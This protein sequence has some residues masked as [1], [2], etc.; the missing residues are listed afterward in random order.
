MQVKKGVYDDA[1]VLV[2]EF[3]VDYQYDEMGRMLRRDDGTDVTDYFY[4]GWDIWK[5]VTGE[6]V[7]EYLVPGLGIQ[8]FLRDGE[9]FTLHSD[10]VSSVR[11][12]TDADGDV[13]ARIELGAWGETLSGSL[14][15]VPGG[16][17]TDFVGALGVR[18]DKMTGLYYMRHRWFEPQ[19][20]RFVSTDPIRL[21]GGT[22]LYAYV[23]NAPTKFV[24]PL[25]LKSD[26]ELA[27]RAEAN[28]AR[29]HC[30]DDKA[31]LVLFYIGGA[32]V[33]PEL[34]LG[35][36]LVGALGGGVVGG[37]IAAA[38]GDNLQEGV[39]QG[40]VSGAATAGALAILGPAAASIVGGGALG[41]S[42]AGGLGFGIG[43]YG[44]QS[45]NVATGRQ[46]VVH[47]DL[48]ATSAVFGGLVGLGLL[49]PFASK[50]QKITSWAGAGD[51]AAL[52][53]GRWV[54]LGG[55][56]RLNQF[57]TG[58]P[59]YPFKNFATGVV[60]RCRLAYPKGWEAF[61]GLIGQR[62]LGK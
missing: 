41:G 24:D 23:G 27:F 62:M 51:T 48:V 45:F 33:A 43:E 25:G 17:P 39:I 55:A 38:G 52:T 32:I 8:S 15:L 4:D 42:V 1:P 61:K 14:D 16:L 10:G 44:R 36:T 31:L 30:N 47:S 5:E 34:V 7:T 60:D 6:S 3:S 40:V 54:Q 58:R 49:R 11:V 56:T 13:A 20:M 21:Q 28:D 9:L 29:D 57:L 37:G 26:V 19:L 35:A 2:N 53:P 18:R 12:V 46:Q 22:N 50:L 59:D